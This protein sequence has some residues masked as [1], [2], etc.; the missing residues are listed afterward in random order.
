MP[1]RSLPIIMNDGMGQA[2]PTASGDHLSPLERGFSRLPMRLMQ[3][4]FPESQTL[5][6]ETRSPSGLSES[7][8]AP[9]L[10]RISSR[11]WVCCRIRFPRQGLSFLPDTPHYF[12][13]GST[14]G[15]VQ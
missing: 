6:R 1:Q 5:L 4:E 8:P 12:P 7:P 10:T 9:N 11:H 14:M 2:I 3:S 13:L 15:F